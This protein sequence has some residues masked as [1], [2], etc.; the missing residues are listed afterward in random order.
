MAA[1]ELEAYLDG[2]GLEFTSKPL[3]AYSKGMK[4]RLALAI[5]MLD[6]GRL[7]I[8]D[9]PN[10]GLDPVGIAMLRA[11]L[12]ALKAVGHHPA[13]L[14]PPPGRGDAPGRPGA[15]PAQG[16]GGGLQLHVRFRRLRR[17][18]A[19]FPGA[20][21]M[22]A[23]G[24]Q[25]L[26]RLLAFELLPSV[27]GPL[28]WAA[29]AGLALLVLPVR[30]HLHGRSFSFNGQLIGQES[31]LAYVLFGGLF[32]DRLHDH[33]AHPVP[34]PGPHRGPL[35]AQQRPAGPVPVRGAAPFYL[36][37]M[38]SVL[39][40]VPALRAARAGACSGRSCTATPG[41]TSTASSPCSCRSP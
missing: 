39:V 5:A 2:F 18:R 40:P 21:A 31:R 1:A 23:S 28:V 25:G 27:K 38:A 3:R 41:S 16:Q 8:L 37:K 10:S 11:K 30:D 34:V 24:R 36:A 14:H 29:L 12:D 32:L 33:L 19:V 9:E 4:Q 22:S 20:G 7:L 17:L 26:A 35:P 15:G 6:C 13:H